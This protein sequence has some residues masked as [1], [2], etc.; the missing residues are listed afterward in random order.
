VL[1]RKRLLMKM[2]M[3]CTSLHTLATRTART[4]TPAC[5]CSV[6]R[7]SGSTRSYLLRRR[8]RSQRLVRV[9]SEGENKEQGTEPSMESLFAKEIQKRSLSGSYSEEVEEKYEDQ[10]ERS[11]KL[12]SEGLDGLPER[13]RQLITLGS[14]FFLSF[15][16]LGAVVAVIFAT[17]AFGLG[18]SFIRTGGSPPPPY[19]DPNDLLREDQAPGA[20]FVKFR[21]NYTDYSDETIYDKES[22]EQQEDKQE[23]TTTTTATVTTTASTL[24]E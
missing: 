22:F 16:P 18:D 23:A 17:M 19:V 15:L 4:A 13:G 2:K 5:C 24:D 12:N 8:K 7:T 3:K 10:L 21:R 1:L 11:R 6:D 20:P 14:T 9:R